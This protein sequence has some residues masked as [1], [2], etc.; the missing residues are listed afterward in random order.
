MIIACKQTTLCIPHFLLHCMQWYSKNNSDCSSGKYYYMELDD[1]SNSGDLKLNLLF[2]YVGC[3]DG[4]GSADVD[5]WTI[6]VDCWKGIDDVVLVIV[7]VINKEVLGS[8]GNDVDDIGEETACGKKT[9]HFMHVW[10]CY[11]NLHVCDPLLSIHYILIHNCT[12][13]K[14]K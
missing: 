13:N 11:K 14:T 8:I 2:G 6:V 10:Y 1:Y 9:C 3:G 7:G 12:K 5:G 4:E